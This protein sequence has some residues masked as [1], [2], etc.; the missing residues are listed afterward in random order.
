MPKQCG[1]VLHLW[2]NQC[3]I[4]VSLIAYLYFSLED[5][6]KNCVSSSYV[7]ANFFDLICPLF[8]KLKPAK[9]I[10][11]PGSFL[12]EVGWPHILYY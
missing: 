5:I 7:A 4:K 9:T 3:K 11:L 1:Y 6:S 10:L 12:A 2:M 8:R